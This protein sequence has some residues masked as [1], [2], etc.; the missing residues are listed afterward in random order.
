MAEQQERVRTIVRREPLIDKQCPLC[1]REF[2]GISRQAYCSNACVNQA[3]YRRH[4]E[5]RRAERRERYRIQKQQRAEED[6]DSR[7]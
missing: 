2:T 6:E 3:S 7:Q 1:G 5:R 4:A